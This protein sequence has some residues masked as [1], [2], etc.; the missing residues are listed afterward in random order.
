MGAVK[1]IQMIASSAPNGKLNP[2]VRIVFE[3]LSSTSLIKSLCKCNFNIAMEYI[4]YNSILMNVIEIEGAK[5]NFY[6][7]IHSVLSRMPTSDKR[8]NAHRL[9][10]DKCLRLLLPLQSSTSHVGR[11][12]YKIWRTTGKKCNLRMDI[13]NELT[14]KKTEFTLGSMVGR[15]NNMSQC[16]Q[17]VT[18]HE[19]K[20]Q[21]CSVIIIAECVNV[22]AMVDGINSVSIGLRMRKIV[23]VSV[24]TIEIFGDQH[25]VVSA[26]NTLIQRM[27]GEQADSEIVNAV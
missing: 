3:R 12:A 26:I 24:R 14:D 18:K 10:A 17:L 4:L 15:P 11:V 8:K 16:I 19:M 20:Q 27:F 1:C 22:E 2:R 6:N 21:E 23:N 5:A 13:V 7:R 9:E 25:N